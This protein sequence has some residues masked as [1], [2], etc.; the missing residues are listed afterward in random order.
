[1]LYTNTFIYIYIY[2]CVCVCVCVCASIHAFC[3]KTLISKSSL[4]TLLL[5]L[6]DIYVSCHRHFFLVLL[7]NQR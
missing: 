2:I 3:I 7:L 6:Y 4:D 5:L 1:M